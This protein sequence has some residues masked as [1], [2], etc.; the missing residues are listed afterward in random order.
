MLIKTRSDVVPFTARRIQLDEFGYVWAFL[1]NGELLRY[2]TSRRESTVI[3]GRFNDVF[4][5]SSYCI[6]TNGKSIF[7]ID[8]RDHKPQ[9]LLTTEFR[10]FAVT[11]REKT[12]DTGV[13]HGRKLSVFDIDGLLAA[14][15]E[16]N[17]PVSLL[18]FIDDERIVCGGDNLTIANIYSGEHEYIEGRFKFFV[19]DLS[20]EP[21]SNVLAVA[22][23]DRMQIF[24]FVDASWANEFTF[25]DEVSRCCFLSPSRLAIGLSEDEDG[26]PTLR[27][28]NCNELD[29]SVFSSGCFCSNRSYAGLPELIVAGTEV[30]DFYEMRG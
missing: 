19:F 30:L 23:R 11:H 9:L 18:R 2:E 26:S 5:C 8:Y 17:A 29:M 6:V 4:F 7:R 10:A 28:E 3:S 22:A 14:E 25:Y 24:R 27:N 16:C 13:F 21:V 1:F 12:G 15:F 20:F